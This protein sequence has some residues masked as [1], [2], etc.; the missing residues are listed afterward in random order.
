MERGG[1]CRPDRR[2]KLVRR[3]ERGWGR[4]G[5]VGIRPERR[6]IAMFTRR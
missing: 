3:R 1:E 5:L 6:G 2:P 4:D